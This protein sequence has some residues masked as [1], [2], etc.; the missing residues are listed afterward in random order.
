MKFS[1]AIAAIS[2]LEFEGKD[3][4]LE[5][6]NSRV[7]ETAMFETKAQGLEK[8]LNTILEMAGATEGDLSKKLETALETVKGLKDVETT[9]KTQLTEKDGVIGQLQ[10]ETKIADA[11]RLS[12][13]N[14]TVLKTLLSSGGGE[15][16]VKEDKVF[17]KPTDGEPTE[18]KAYAE[19]NW[20]DFNS[21]LF[22]SST[23]PL[24]LPSGGSQGKV[25]DPVDPVS[26]FMKASYGKVAE[27]LGGVDK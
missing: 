16:E 26:Q 5:A 24:T 21:A 20:K 15:L 22:T 23:P 6:I 19:A 14:P 13:A 11:V 25:P 10:R 27:S 4:V 7:K 1:D 2:G 8:N 12:G 3:A 18:L 17:F 9:Y